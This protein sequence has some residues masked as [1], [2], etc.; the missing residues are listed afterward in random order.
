MNKFFYVDLAG[1]IPFDLAEGAYL[2]ELLSE[3]HDQ[4][5]DAIPTQGMSG[6]VNRSKDV[7]RQEHNRPSAFVEVGKSQLRASNHV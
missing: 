3:S 7:S 6:L 2:W 5:F 1:A 4:S